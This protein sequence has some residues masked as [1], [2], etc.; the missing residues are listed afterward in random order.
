M[1]GAALYTSVYNEKTIS[2]GVGQI[3]YTKS[4]KAD[5]S[6][7]LSGQSN[8]Q[9][10]KQIQYIGENGGSVSSDDS[11]MV[12]GTANPSPYASIGLGINTD[13]PALHGSDK[14]ICVFGGGNEP[15]ILPAFCNS[16]ESSSSIF[17]SVANVMTTSDVRFIVSSAD[18]PVTLGHEIRVTDSVGKAEAGMEVMIMES[19]A[20]EEKF[21][22]AFSVYPEPESEQR[23]DIAG[24][25]GISATEMMESLEASEYTSIDGTIRLFDKAMR[26]DSGVSR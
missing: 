23:Y 26:Y 18:T 16:A 11:I 8:I 21:D 9:A 19:S 6:A 15:G 5:T 13:P 20:S 7:A 25:V 4:L 14:V 12:S 10:I 17:M 24:W 22:F 3:G 2:N 1:N